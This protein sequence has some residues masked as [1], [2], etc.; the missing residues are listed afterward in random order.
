MAASSADRGRL[1]FAEEVQQTLTGLGLGPGP[2]P[3]GN[4]EETEGE[5]L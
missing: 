5:P 3:D 4:G 2:F 1:R